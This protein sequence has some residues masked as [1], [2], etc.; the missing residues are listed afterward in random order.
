MIELNE[1]V[2]LVLVQFRCKNWDAVPEL[3]QDILEWNGLEDSATREERYERMG[4]GVRVIA[5]TKNVSLAELCEGFESAGFELVD[6]FNA[7]RSRGIGDCSGSGYDRVVIS[8]FVFV[9]SEDVYNR[10]E[11]RQSKLREAFAEICET[12]F[13]Q[14]E[15]YL[16]PYFKDN[17]VVDGLSSVSINCNT[18]IP[19]FRPD[20]TP[21]MRWQK[22]ADGNRVGDAPQPLQ[23][24]HRLTVVDNAIIIT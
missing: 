4:S 11:D 24:D 15:A 17:E 22:D 3:V 1:N 18:R 19:L 10:I 12:A 9:R 13:W 8:R 2:R 14:A 20:G 16:N 5:P 6:G 21:E 7:S 23:P